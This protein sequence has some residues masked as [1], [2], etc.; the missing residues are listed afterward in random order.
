MGKSK[1]S[2]L[3]VLIA[4]D[5]DD[6]AL[7]I[8]R[9]LKRGGYN[10]NMLRVDSASEMQ[11]ALESQ[12][13][14]LIITDHN[15]PSF[16]SNDAL[17]LT[18]QYDQNIPFILVSGSIGEEIA[19]DAMRAGAQDYVMKD[20]LAR[21]LPAIERELREAVNRRE[22]QKAEATIRH[23]AFHDSLTDLINRAEFERRLENAVITAK[24]DGVQHCLL[25]LDL[26]QF[27]LVNDSC[28]HMAGDELL[29]RITRRLHSC[30]RDSDTLA[31]LGGDEF[32]VLLKNCPREQAEKIAQELLKNI[33][34][35]IFI[36][37]DSSFKIGVSIGLVQIDGE[38]SSKELLSI[39]DITCYAAKDLGR[40]RVHIYSESDQT[41]C[42]RK[43][44]T[45]WIQRLQ[46]S[47]TNNSLVLYQHQIKSLQGCT[48]HSEILLRMRDD[49]GS[50]IAPDRFI[51]AAE[52]YNIM[53]E[54][55]RWVIRHA[56]EQFK[57]R[58]KNDLHSVE[59]DT[60]FINL[61][62]TSLSDKSLSRYIKDQL[63]HYSIHPRNVGFEI[64][65]TAAIADFDYAMNLITE[66]QSFGCKVALDDFGTGMS[67]FSYLKSLN[68]DYVKIDGGFVKNMIENE[69]DC[70][71]VEAVNK[72]GHIAGMKT[73]A[74]YVENKALLKCLT[75]LGVDFAQ[76]WAVEY[77]KPFFASETTGAK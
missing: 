24:F 35:Y 5:S 64:T 56:C 18:R 41:L 55:D 38:I 69:M 42:Q 2:T 20:N 58:H 8:K 22:R 10:P 76:G 49:D 45:Q 53:P 31:R 52:R 70:A 43:G 63:E 3:K 14:D 17:A 11:T 47:M 33:Q 44:E 25:Y 48:S 30:I 71:I 23:M 62:A 26:D 21:L 27:K 40:N 16:N 1:G 46:E 13:W 4:E 59:N 75:R 67:S 32:G 65:E 19:V 6:D 50:L 57:K 39:A 7:L 12:S 61:S 28:G 73:I 74:E 68:V 15:M 66:L 51:P 60:I 54:V 37:S 34:A 72:I 36:W 9:E 77:P 29:R